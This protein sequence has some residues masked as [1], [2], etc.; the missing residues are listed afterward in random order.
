MVRLKADNKEEIEIEFDLRAYT[1][2]VNDF[3]TVYS[4]YRSIYPY[5]SNYDFKPYDVQDKL[6]PEE[7]N[8]KTVLDNGTLIEYNLG[9]Y[10]VSRITGN[11]LYAILPKDY[12]Q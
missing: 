3:I 12:M 6:L 5:E 2:K 8:R 10:K 11:K 7:V 9:R 1:V 4:W